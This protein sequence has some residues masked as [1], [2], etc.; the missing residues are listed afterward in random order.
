MGTKADTATRQQAELLREQIHFHNYRYYVLDD[1][2]IPD[3]EYD[4]LM[5]QLRQLEQ[6]YPELI[7][8]QSPT[9]RVGGAPIDEFTQIEHEQPMLSLDNAFTEED[10]IS[11]DKSIRERLAVDSVEY[12]GEA[13]LDGLAISLLYENGV[14]ARAATRGD[15]KTGEDVTHNVKT[16]KAIPLVLQGS[17]YPK[18]LEVRGEIFMT[19]AGFEKLNKQQLAKEEKTFANPRNAAAGSLRQLDPRI[20]AKRPL[21]F[22]CYSTGIVEQG[23]LPIGQY[24]LIQKLRDWGFPV[25]NEI[26]L[27]PD[28]SSCLKF[29]QQVLAVRDSLAHE[30]DGVVY[31]VNDLA[32]QQRLGYVS[33]APRWARAHKFPAEEELTVVL[34][35]DIQVGRTGALTP[36]ARLEPVFVGGVTVTNATL[37]NE[38]EVARKDVR[39]GDTVVV[40][41]AGDVIPEVVRVVK[42]RRPDETKSFAMPK[43]CPVCHSAVAQED[44]VS[45]CTGG[46][47]CGAQRREHF[48]HF[49]SR[50]A[51][52]ID[53]LGEKLIE[54]LLDKGLVETVADLYQ[55]NREELI[56]LE[57][58]AEKSA[59]NLL[60]A[61]EK[62][63]QT[64]LPRFLFALGIREVGSA[65]A[66]GLAEF[67]GSLDEI[68]AA[69]VDKLTEVPDVGPVVA[70]NIKQF[71]TQERH[72]EV[73]RKMISMGV[74]WPDFD[75]K[76]EENQELSGNTYVITGTLESLS[77]DQA[78][79]QL[80]ALGAKVTNSVSAKTTALIAGEKAGSKLSKAEKLGVDILNESQLLALLS[81]SEKES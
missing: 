17:D 77:R 35:V 15:G 16:I 54:Q 19:R 75:K 21:S 9:Q 32:Q 47:I 49:V 67:F 45:R 60:A 58:M 36:V 42:S 23:E 64:S 69:D 2:D 14:L 50:Q 81:E 46:L 27:L 13:K 41:R 70:N 6:K 33:R 74:I 37:H 39:V 52:D 11:F 1:P 57:R 31:K 26:E 10:I 51:M 44:T 61:L 80:M 29:Y 7:S 66:Q 53:G 8:A 63:K 78:K 48:K 62:S 59:D 4:R 20:T 3:A 68:I 43:H 5:V 40:R 55:L 28:V 12:I 73:I 34:D 72:L 18:R 38:S 71:F 56:S 24:Q 22:Y 79:A 65:T 76:N 30:I 25:Q